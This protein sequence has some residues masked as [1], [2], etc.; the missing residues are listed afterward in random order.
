[1]ILVNKKNIRYSKWLMAT[2]TN[3]DLWFNEDS[4]NWRCS[5]WWMNYSQFKKSIIGNDAVRKQFEKNRI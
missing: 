2:A 4:G 5:W 3:Y 1:L